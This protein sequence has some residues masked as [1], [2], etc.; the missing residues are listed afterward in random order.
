MKTNSLRSIVVINLCYVYT[1][2][3][4]IDINTFI[5]P[6]CFQDWTSCSHG[7]G[8][9]AVQYYSNKKI[10]FM[11][12]SLTRYQYLSLCYI[13]RHRKPQHKETYPSVVQENTWHGW[14]AFFNG[15][16]NM[17]HPY[18]TCTVCDR[19]GTYEYRNYHDP[20][21]NIRL[22]YI[23]YRG[24]GF[25]KTKWLETYFP[26]NVHI[27][28]V[29]TNVGFFGFHFSNS[30][31]QYIEVLQA[32]ADKV[33]WKTTTYQDGEHNDPEWWERHSDASANRTTMN[34]MDTYMCNHEGVL[35]LDTSWTATHAKSTNYWDTTHFKEPIYA[36]L[37]DELLNILLTSKV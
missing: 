21:L 35:C 11:G 28:L 25:E 33:V 23:Q 24:I 34:S 14:P 19:G 18:E 31:V 8:N 12:D 32:L 36:M 30:Y 29:V 13:L 7:L 15:S 9:K 5:L 1:V 37:N 2:L 20:H 22:T 3:T 6:K 10:L 16:S 26:N 4:A 27:D 17:L